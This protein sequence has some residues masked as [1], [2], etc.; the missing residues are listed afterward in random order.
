[1]SN[2]S[3]HYVDPSSTDESQYNISYEQHSDG[4]NK[5][6]PTFN[7]Y[8]ADI[9]ADASDDDLRAAYTPC[10]TIHSVYCVR[11]RTTG[12]I[13]GYG[14]V[15]FLS[16]EAREAALN[17]HRDFFVQG[18]KVRAFRS[19]DKSTLFLGNLP[20][21][22]TATELRETLEKIAGPIA[23]LTLKNGF[24]FA[25]YANFRQAE[26][27]SALLRSQTINGVAIKV[28][29]AISQDRK[30]NGPDTQR[31][32][33][34]R[35][36]APTVTDDSL[37]AH[38]SKYGGVSKAN[39]ARHNRTGASRC[40]GFIEMATGADATAALRGCN[41]SAL[42]GQNITVEYSRPPATSVAP[43]RRLAPSAHGRAAA[44]AD[45]AAYY[46]AVPT[47]IIPTM[48][49][50]ERSG[51]YVLLSPQQQYQLQ[52]QLYAAPPPT[53]A[54]PAAYPAYDAR[55]AAA[56]PRS[57]SSSREYDASRRDRPGRRYNPY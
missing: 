4:E 46:P 48:A 6:Q 12:K 56:P 15:N 53:A 2:E 27:A 34:V 23:S 17:P 9:P 45:E 13:K 5:D 38:F 52:Q 32:L 29:T 55:T 41:N 19:T 49:Y 35:N 47:T 11:D 10:G 16:S 40:F 50:D 1:M 26:R 54:A 22:I 8:V 21:G 33:Y 57:T 18:K 31:T 51:Q 30:N 14:F 43:S 28:Q 37:R 44:P 39:V 20:Q 42:E 3:E 25:Q 24:A 7:I 36:L